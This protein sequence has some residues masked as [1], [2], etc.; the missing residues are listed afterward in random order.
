MECNETGEV[1]LTHVG[2]YKKSRLEVCYDG[3]W[4]SV[5]LKYD[6]TI[7]GVVCRQLGYFAAG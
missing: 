1:R 3:N 6:A 2:N 7:A 4:G 5:C